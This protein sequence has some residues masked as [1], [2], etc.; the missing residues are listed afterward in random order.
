M[1]AKNYKE[2]IPNYYTWGRVP[3]EHR[4][5]KQWLKRHRRLNKAAGP[6]GTITLIFDQP[7]ERP[8][9]VQPVSVE[10]CERLRNKFRVAAPNAADQFDLR[11]LDRA[12]QL[13]GINLY[14]I[15]DTQEITCFTEP[16]AEELLGYMLWD[17]SHSQHYITEMPETPESERERRTWKWDT[18]LPDFKDHLAGER[19]FGHKKGQKTM[20]VTVEGDRHRGNVPGNQH[21][22]WALKVGEVLTNRFPEFRF[23]PEITKKNGSV[24]FFGWLPECTP[25]PLA[26]KTGEQVRAVLQQELPEYD[27]THTEIFPSS[28]PQIFAPLRADKIMV[29]GTGVV[30]KVERYRMPLEGG[31]RKRQPYKT[32]SCADY[33]NWVCFS[34]TPFNPEVFE[35]HLREAVARC[36]DTPATENAPTEVKKAGTRRRPTAPEWGASASCKGAAP[37]PWSISGPNWNCPKTTPSASTSL[38][39][40]ASSD[41]KGLPRTRPSSG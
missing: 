31:K 21:I 26:E 27:F 13:V 38:S 34:N 35:H 20:Q 36:P 11:R 16:E 10:D 29:V 14:D 6:V 9:W 12:G 32:Y 28:S 22:T 4:T 8:K 41:T 18:G 15:Q 17:G 19:Y 23:S 39:P 3:S 33:L 7:R 40:C 5:K 30:K 2:E 24:K 25:M 37:R 1:I